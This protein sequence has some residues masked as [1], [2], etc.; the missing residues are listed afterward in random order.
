[1]AVSS[2]TN[3][4]LDSGAVIGGISI[5]TGSVDPSNALT[6]SKGS[7]YIRLDTGASTTATRLY[8]NT[9]GSSIWTALTTAA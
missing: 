6:A 1:M 2:A 3:T 9:T 4:V 5:N 8:I 7:L